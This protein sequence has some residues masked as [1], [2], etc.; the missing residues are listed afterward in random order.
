[1]GEGHLRNKIN[2]RYRRK[3]AEHPNLRVV[4]HGDCHFWSFKVCTC[5]LLH[6]LKWLSDPCE[7][8]EN[9]VKELALQTVSMDI[10]CNPRD[11]P[12]E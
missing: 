12:E 6:D 2:D 9:F 7:I 1:M 11:R 3:V 8:Y 5:G 10:I 4:H